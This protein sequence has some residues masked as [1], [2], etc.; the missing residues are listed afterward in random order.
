MEGIQE[1]EVHEFDFGAAVAVGGCNAPGDIIAVPGSAISSEE[2]TSNFDLD[3]EV[4]F[5]LPK[6]TH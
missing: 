6:S 1:D 5:Q 2:A 4:S 3:A